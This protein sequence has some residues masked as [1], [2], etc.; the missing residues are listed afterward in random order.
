MRVSFFFFFFFF[1]CFYI[2]A[3]NNTCPEASNDFYFVEKGGSISIYEGQGLLI[4]DFDANG[5]KLTASLVSN[6]SNGTVNMDAWGT[7]A[8]TYNHDGSDTKS[9]SFTY[10]ISDGTCDS[11]VATVTINVNINGKWYWSQIG[12]DTG[13]GSLTGLDSILWGYSVSLNDDGTR[14]ALGGPYSSNNYPGGMA[15][16][17]EYDQLNNIWNQ[18]GNNLTA[19]ANKDYYGHSVSLSGDGKIIAAG[20]PSL[21]PDYLGVKGYTRVFKLE[22]ATPIT[23][24]QIGQD[25]DGE[26]LG[27]QSGYSVS[28]STDGTRVAIGA[29]SNDGNGNNSGHVRVYNRDGNSWKQ[30]GQDINGEAAD[31]QSGYSVSLSGDGS[32]VAIG[33]PGNDGNVY[34][35]G[36]VRVYRFNGGGSSNCFSNLQGTFNAVTTTKGSWSHVGGCSVTS[37]KTQYEWVKSFEDNLYKV[38]QGDFTYGIYPACYGSAWMQNNPDAD[39]TLRVKDDCGTLSPIGASKWGELFQF[40][41]VSVSFSQKELTIDWENDYGEAGLSVLT[42]W[43]NGDWPDYLNNQAEWVQL[44]LGGFGEDI[45]GEAVNDM[46]GNSVSLSEDG[47]RVAIG[48]VQNSQQAG[49]VRVYQW[50]GTSWYKIAPDIDGDASENFTGSD[51]SLSKNGTILAVGAYG[52]NNNT[53]HVRIY[54]L[55]SGGVW[56][57]IGSDINGDFEGDRSGF[58][59]SLSG[60][61]KR[62]AIGSPYRDDIA[63]EPGHVKVYQITPNDCPVGV[64]DAYSLDQGTELTV[65][66]AQGVLANDTDADGDTLLVTIQ[67]STLYGLITLNTDGSFTYTHDGSNN[68]LDSLS[69]KVTDGRCNSNL[70]MVNLTINEIVV[71]MGMEDRSPDILKIYPNPVENR[72]KMKLED[73]VKV[74]KVEFIDYSGKMYTPT[75]IT[76]EGNELT[77]YI[78]NL[79]NGNYILTLVTDKGF[80][81]SKVVVER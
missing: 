70:T 52:N 58:S 67:D 15:F 62:V 65:D 46:S 21:Y 77:I 74:K 43:S 33:A 32:T 71:P 72:L 61:G 30:L 18:I 42:D 22:Q 1:Y 69:Y 16:L 54:H 81:H 2:K 11:N 4:N 10:K 23:F 63:G 19:K 8:F 20:A 28:L 39:G 14:V 26:A 68:F 35:S 57:Q 45:D 53:G 37:P 64:D 80:N 49:H 59:L 50:S 41:D 79:E 17:Y 27:D 25:I 73:N 40:N 78:S 55:P 66:I 12:P 31:D 3:Q 29:I 34:N 24:S 47:E 51:I 7:G 38:V 75:K 5:D 6:P 48:S 44:G 60:D 13:L 36:H 56:T 76:R 9:D